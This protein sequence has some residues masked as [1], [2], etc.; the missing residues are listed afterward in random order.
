MAAFRFFTALL[1]GDGTLTRFGDGTSTWRDYAHVDDVVD[2]L[3]RA[4]HRGDEGVGEGNED[5]G[6]G[7]GGS[8]EIVNVASGTPTRLGAFIDACVDACGGGGGASSPSSFVVEERPG[9]AGDVGG[10]YADVEKASRTLNGWAPRVSLRDGL[11]AT[12]EWY[13]TEEAAA[14]RAVE[15]E[16]D[17]Q[18]K[19]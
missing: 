9:R 4:M 18:R 8:F 16:D 6:R 10:T 12:A 14:W 3:I 1:F 2:A 11:R 15:E 13:R 5:A 7:P 19:K 17:A